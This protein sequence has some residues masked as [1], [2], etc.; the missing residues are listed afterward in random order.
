MTTPTVRIPAS[1]AVSATV[2]AAPVPVP[3]PM[4]AVMKTMSLSSMHLEM[5]LRLSSALRLPTSGSLPAPWP[6]VSF[7]PICTVTSALETASAC[8]SVLTAMN[9]TPF[10]PEATIRF[11]TLF[12]APPTPTTLMVTTLSGPVSGTN[13]AISVSSKSFYQQFRK[14]CFM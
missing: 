7:S 1:L 6:W 8:L 3:P 11:T 4:P 14:G 13:A 12:P 5:L 2:G 10:V 9:S